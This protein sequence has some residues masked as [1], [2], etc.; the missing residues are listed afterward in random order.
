MIDWQPT[1][2]VLMCVYNGEKY[3]REAIDSI[4]HQTYTDF[5]LIIVND[6]STDTSEEIIFLYNDERIK[7][8]KN[9]TNLRLQAS[10][11][12]G[13]ENCSGRFI[14]RMD[15]D[16]ISL[17]T[18]FQQQVEFLEYHPEIGVVGTG[19][20]FIDGN[21]TQYE[22]VQYPASPSE[23]QWSLFFSCPIVHP[24]VMMRKEVIDSVGGYDTQLKHAEDYDL[25]CRL[26]FVTKF[27][28]LENT[29]LKLRKHDSNASLDYTNLINQTVSISQNLISKFLHVKVSEKLLFNYFN[30][31]KFENR[32]EAFNMVDLYF[33]VY[34]QQVRSNIVESDAEKK[35]KRFV[36]SNAFTLIRS[37][38]WNLRSVLIIIKCI[39]IDPVF[40]VYK[41]IKRSANK[42]SK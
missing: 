42:I 3:L 21:G 33:K 40:F 39:Y 24:S 37:R 10:L 27:S 23:L 20:I 14:A 6:G 38:I 41:I 4:L 13:L 9:E 17:P 28:N 36:I 32:H 34:K 29:L 7:Y 35:L 8:I 25:W 16:D 19:F 18:R 11:N 26:C 22:S 1:V 31:R 12:K 2:S 5:E 30:N 15:A